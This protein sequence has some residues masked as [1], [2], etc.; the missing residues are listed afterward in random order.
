VLDATPSLSETLIGES[1]ARIA[2]V[3]LTRLVP[4]QSGWSPRLSSTAQCS[5]L[6]GPVKEIRN[7]AL[8][9]CRPGKSA[10]SPN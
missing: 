10:T 8:A 5:P 6:L 4:R 3:S 1:G 2:A 7:A 9:I